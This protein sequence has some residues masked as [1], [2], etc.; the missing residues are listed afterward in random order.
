MLGRSGDPVVPETQRY[1]VVSLSYHL[2]DV[3]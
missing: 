2:L 1:D 3:D